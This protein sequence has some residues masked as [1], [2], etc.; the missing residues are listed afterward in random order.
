MKKYKAVSP[1]KTVG[2]IKSILNDIGILTREEYFGNNQFHSC[3]I[4]IGNSDI[5]SLN[6][7]SNGKGRSFEYTPL[8]VVMLNSWR[9]FKTTCFYLVDVLRRINSLK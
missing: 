1:Y 9:G 3:R 8:L 6:I 7:G 4:S 2:S 5:S